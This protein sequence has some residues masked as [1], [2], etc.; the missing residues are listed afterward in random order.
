MPTRKTSLTMDAQILD[1]AKSYGI[2]VSAAAQTGVE[3]VVKAER[4][5]RWK[6]DNRAGIEEYNRWVEKNGILLSR[7][8]KF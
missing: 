6:E 7:Y 2:N 8:R 4:Q 1:E 5:R 3:A